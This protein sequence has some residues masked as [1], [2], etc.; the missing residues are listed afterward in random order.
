MFVQLTLAPA[1]VYMTLPQ[2]EVGSFFG[3]G[4][5]GAYTACIN[6]MPPPAYNYKGIHDAV[7]LEV[8]YTTAKDGSM[9]IKSVKPIRCPAP[10]SETKEKS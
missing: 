7:I 6:R 5:F 2:F 10:S 9:K 3:N 1:P 4:E 8:H